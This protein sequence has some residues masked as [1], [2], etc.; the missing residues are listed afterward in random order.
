MPCLSNSLSILDIN[1]NPLAGA[2][3]YVYQV[4]NNDLTQDATDKYIADE[5]KFVGNTDSD[6]QY[7]IP[8]QMDKGWDDPDTDEVDG[9]IN[10]WNPF[11]RVKTDTA[12]TYN[13]SSTEGLLLIKIV[14]GDQ[15]EQP[16]CNYRKGGQMILHNGMEAVS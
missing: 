9:S 2:A 4:F 1:D 10:V 8:N 16:G 3:V 6:G 7:L 14:S 5:P 15:V 13:V 11:G 12:Y